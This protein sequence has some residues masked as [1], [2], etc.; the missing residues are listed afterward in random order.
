LAISFNLSLLFVSPR[1]KNDDLSTAILKQKTRPNRLIVDES[2][3]ED[4]SVVS[5]SQAK[6]D[7]LQLFRG[8]TVLMKGK[9]R[10]ESV[11]IVLSDDTCSDEK[12]RMNRVVRNNLRVR[13]GD[14]ISIQPCPD[15]KYG[16]RIHVLPIDDTVEGITGNLFEV[17]LKPYFL[18]AYRPIRKGDI[19]LVRGGMRAVEFK[20]VETD[21][22][23]YCIVAPDTVIHCEGEPIRREDEEESLNE[24]G[25]D[26]I[27]GVRKQL[28]QIKEMVELPLRH[29][30][31]FK[32]IGVK[33]PRGIL[34]YGPPGTGKTLIARA[35]ANET[36][37]FFFLINGPEIM[38]KLAGESESNLRKAFE[39]AEKNSPAIIFIDELDAIA[40][41]REK[42]HGEVERRIVSQ[43]LTLM[44]GLKQR[45]H[46]IV[47]AAT[48]RPNSIDAA[49]RR[50]GRF[51]REVDIGIPDATGRL[52][53]LQIH[54]KNM[55]L[56]DDVDLEQ[57]ANETHGHVG[58]DL[59][60]L[61][62][63]AALQAIRKKMD[64]IDLED[65]T[66]DAEVMNSL[67][68][69]MD[70]FRWALSQSNPSALRETVVEV[71][72]IT[73]GDIGGLEDVKR[74][75]QELVQYPVEH[76]DKFLKF[77]MTPSKGVL[78]YGPPGCGKTLLA[79]AIANECQANFISIK[80]PELLTMWFGESEANVREIFDKARQA[81]PCVLFFDELDS[82][83]KARGG[84]VGDGGGAADRVINQIL[85]EMDG[86]S[87]KKNVFIIG[88]TNR[89]DII[90][91]AI[92][93]PG[94][95]DQLI[96]IPLPDE[97]SRIN[98]L[99]ANLRKSP[100]SKDVDLD[101]LAKMTNG[102]SGADLTE[103]C[104]R[105][106]KL[107]IRECI[108][109]EI[110][111]ERERQ[112]N[113]SA[114]EVEEDDPVPEIRKD[115]FEEAMRFARRSVSDNDIRKYEMF[116]QTLQQSRG[117]G[118][119][120][121]PSSAAGGSGPSQGTGGTGGGPVFNEDNDDDLY[122]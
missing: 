111:R 75:L 96:Y 90:D 92:L 112:T 7:E 17:Y 80:G 54:T 77:G 50:F 99:K 119:F 12:I 27:G 53:I 83:A 79:K 24:V 108:E 121:F 86:M 82:I 58:A 51:D 47:M 97:K 78:F 28:A 120:R 65:E 76:P 25:Y 118:S 116:A 88:A 67:A 95:L 31:L 87:S 109:N 57:V 42:T 11:C 10:R 61:C 107:A 64:L 102:F 122:G 46:V 106:C 115:H 73:W 69:T 8:D 43:L 94:R 91:P 18:E 55:K 35:V 3:N 45:A 93:R 89:P 40:P 1:S 52:E 60:A 30:A 110:R 104:Q 71:P 38:S 113:P 101:F 32:A 56:N 39:E 81:A 114:M 85:T 14:V 37:A 70:D 98:I 48:N 84:N 44:D 117:F 15:V 5:L 6:M 103:I 100:I 49:L 34:L 74:E 26:D 13:L 62:S 23:P 63:E 41:K 59:A 33:P 21:P 4:N 19:F 68:V 105:A 9:K 2:I 66:I 29:P 22:N 36:G 72:N 20:V 16:K